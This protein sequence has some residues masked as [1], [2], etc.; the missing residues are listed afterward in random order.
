VAAC[1]AARRLKNQREIVGSPST[2]QGSVPF[3]TPAWRRYYRQGVDAAWVGVIGTLAGAIVGFGGQYLQ[4][5]RQRRWQWEDARIA[6]REGVAGQLRLHRLEVYGTAVRS[7]AGFNSLAAQRSYAPAATDSRSQDRGLR[8]EDA[9]TRAWAELEQRFDEVRLLGGGELEAVTDRINEACG[10]IMAI[11][12]GVEG[13]VRLPVEELATFIEK[14]NA[15]HA[16]LVRSM[17]AETTEPIAE[18]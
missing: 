1:S 9:H 2:T 7:F 17:K 18:P 13:G 4:G 12:A 3:V 6:A 14:L 10:E 5:N 8:L 16:E 15:L 11:L